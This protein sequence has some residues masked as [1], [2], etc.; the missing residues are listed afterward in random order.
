MEGVVQIEKDFYFIRQ[1]TRPGWFC[2][3]YVITGADS[4]GI[5]DSGFEN[6]PS[7]WWPVPG[8]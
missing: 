2:G 8:P 1:V 6:T 3:I 7:E 4:I 5:V